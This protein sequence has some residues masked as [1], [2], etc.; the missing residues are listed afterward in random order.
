[1]SDDENHFHDVE[2]RDEISKTPEKKY[3]FIAFKLNVEK[4]EFEELNISDEEHVEH[5]LD[6]DNIL[7]FSDTRNS[8]IWIWEGRKTTPKMKFIS[9]QEAPFIRD[10][11]GIDYTIS[12]IDDG[13]EPSEFKILLGLEIEADQ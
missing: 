4:E 12:T 13:D 10:Q 3:N 5:L 9:A 11:Y 2:K 6:S 8:K 7:L 1:M